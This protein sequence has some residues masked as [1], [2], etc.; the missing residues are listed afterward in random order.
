MLNTQTIA[1]A[2][3]LSNV[4]EKILR[5]T[6]FLA[7]KL[8][9]KKV[10][11]VHVIP[12][13]LS[14][15][16]ADLEMHEIL[17]A[18]FSLKKNIE[19][20]IAET[21]NGIFQNGIMTEIAVF[22]GNPY[23]DLIGRADY[24]GAGLV[25]IGRKKESDHSGITARRVARDFYGNVLFVPE[26]ATLALQNI[27]VPIDFSENSSR[28]LRTALELSEKIQNCKVRCVHIVSNIPENYYLDLKM[29][30]ELNDKLMNNAE[31]AWKS[32][33]GKNEWT[34]KSIR[35]DF[36]QQTESNISLLLRDFFKTHFTDLVI[37]GAKGHTA[38]ENFLYGSVTE[39][40]VDNFDDCPVLIVR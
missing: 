25:V 23:E 39:Q 35:I 27:I 15:G 1:V 5:Y 16:H 6:Q 26:E 38:F 13:I 28:A 12:T 31:N 37:M 24:M 3:D 36:I 8:Y 20:K 30:K 18:S 21:R 19:A 10:S 7:K 9:V 22:E 34:K 32:F 2:V 14:P 29:R 11:L 40:L 17:G 33:L 4:D